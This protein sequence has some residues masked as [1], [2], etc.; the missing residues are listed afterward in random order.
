MNAADLIWSAADLDNVPSADILGDLPP[1]MRLW[2]AAWLRTSPDPC[3]H[4]GEGVILWRLAGARRALCMPC[5]VAGGLTQ[6][7]TRCGRCGALADEGALFAV[8]AIDGA[9]AIACAC[10]GCATDETDPTKGTNP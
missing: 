9:M 3:E 7:V 5:A 2:L 1:R 10:R 8:F 4:A 6:L